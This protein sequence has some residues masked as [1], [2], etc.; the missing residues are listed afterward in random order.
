[1]IH[2]MTIQMKITFDEWAKGSGSWNNRPTIAVIEPSAEDRKKQKDKTGS[3]V[4]FGFIRVLYREHNDEPT[5]NPGI[6]SSSSG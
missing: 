6:A 4:P 5:T 2:P 3:K 1:M